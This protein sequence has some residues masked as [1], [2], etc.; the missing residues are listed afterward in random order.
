MAS[1]Y[2]GLRNLDFTQGIAGPMACMLL[3]DFEAEVIKVEPPGGDRLKQDPGYLAWNRNKQVVSLDLASYAGLRAAKDLIATADVAVFDSPP[4]ELERR[5]LDATTL[6]AAHPGLLHACLPP[7][8]SRG[9]W[10]QLPPSEGLL[11]AVSASAWMQYSYEDRPTCLVTPQCSYGH[12]LIA[13][14]QLAAAIFERARSGRGQALTVTGLDGIAAIQSGGAIMAS[15]VFRLGGRRGSRGGVPNYRLYR[16]ADGQWFFLGCLTPAFFLRALEVLDLL[17]VMALEGVDGEFTNLLK[18][19]MNEVVIER[20]D[21]RFAGRPRA[22][23]M[24]VLEENGIPRG[25]VGRRE[26]WFAGETV[27]ANGMRVELDDA[28]LGTVAIPGVPVKLAATPGSVRHLPRPVRPDALEPHTPTID[29]QAEPPPAA[30]PLDSVRVLDLASF[31]AG[32]YAPTVL[33]SMGA[34][35]VKV[36]SPEGDGF[37]TYGLGFVGFN[38]GKRS[39]VLDLKTQPGRDA[40]YDLVRQSDVVVDNYRLGVRERLGVGYATLSA[41]NPR[42]ITC[43]V[44]GYGPEGP[45]SRDPGFDPLLQ[46]RSG[47][48]AGQGGQDEPVFYQIPVNDN[49]AAI[50][51]A[52]GACIALYAREFSGHGQEVTTCLANQAVLC[53]SGEIVAYQGRPPAPEGAL[54][55]LGTGAL[56]RFYPCADGWLAVFCDSAPQFHQ[57]CLALGHSEWAGRYLADRAMVEPVAGPLAEA[58]AEALAALTVKEATD[59]LLSRGVP[60]APALAYERFF[61]DP[62]MRENGFFEEYQHPQFGTLT[63]PARYAGWSR[64]PR[65]FGPAA[66]LLGQHSVEVL[67]EVGFDEKRIAELLASGI[68]TQAE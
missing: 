63:G 53:Q 57:L 65:R 40:F 36:E 52:M 14:A 19:P 20:L 6:A 51:T 50:T 17:E 37:R 34:D 45:L 60:A 39:L 49:A 26:E 11:Q 67:R 56:Q 44:T 47:M 10:S 13:A 61:G 21:A 22:E 2:S 28:R 43:S 62:F 23:W 25:P 5:G 3:S 68:V 41:V 8:A 18:P 33:A 42:I 29:G 59:R 38:R 66:P 32:T 55:C 24:K 4:G 35:V 9:R 7:Y 64:T 54:D 1:A 15:E 30:G 27:A 46:A 12:A 16:C 58:I 48:M 31:I